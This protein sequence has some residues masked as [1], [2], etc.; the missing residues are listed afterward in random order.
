MR[1]TGTHTEPHGKL[2]HTPLA[3]APLLLACL[4]AALGGVAQTQ[5]KAQ[6]LGQERTKTGWH[7][8]L[9]TGMG[10]DIYRDYGTSPLAY[11]GLT[12]DMEARAIA[13]RPS[14]M[15]MEVYARGLAGLH[16]S[17]F[18]ASLLALDA[19]GGASL[20]GLKALWHVGKPMAGGIAPF[21]GGSLNNLLLIRY[22]RHHENASVGLGEFVLPAL[23]GGLERRWG[24]CTL[25]GGLAVAPLALFLRPGYAYI[26]NYAEENDLLSTLGNEYQWAAKPLPAMATTLGARWTLP[27]GN[28][29][30]CAYEWGYLGTGRH[31]AWKY[32]NAIH[33]LSLYLDFSLR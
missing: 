26:D 24:R 9:A 6:G 4:L 8:R 20:L 13:T 30:G 10:R 2:A 32:Q 5:D 29:L 7:L 15:R 21:I 18:S 28:R 22:N 31:G 17:P 23:H 19:A 33:H 25:Y 16:R 1:H 11:K 14:G 12:A 3:H 27:G